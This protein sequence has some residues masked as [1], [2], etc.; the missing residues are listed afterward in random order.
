MM[1]LV[2]SVLGAAFGFLPV[3]NLLVLNRKLFETLLG[4]GTFGTTGELKLVVVV[5]T[6]LD[7]PELGFVKLLFGELVVM[8]IFPLLLTVFGL[9]FSLIVLPLIVL[10]LVLILVVTCVVGET[11]KFPR[12]LLSLFTL[13]LLAFT[14]LLFVVEE[15]DEVD[16][17]IMPDEVFPFKAALFKTLVVKEEAP[18]LDTPLFPTDKTMIC[19]AEFPP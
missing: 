16:E 18:E 5:V 7:E 8:T 15:D 11:P 14:V 13:L 19:E 9:V 2:I 12:M 1:I 4:L 10:V 17:E 6:E 3:G